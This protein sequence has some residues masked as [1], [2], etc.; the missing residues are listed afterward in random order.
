MSAPPAHDGHPRAI[1]WGMALLAAACV[2]LQ[3]AGSLPL[4][5]AALA[6]WLGA[7]AALDRPSLRRL[8]MPR[9]RRRRS[10]QEGGG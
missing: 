2:A 3:F 5:G 1:R 10:G 8:W 7:L 4:T 9:F 6:L